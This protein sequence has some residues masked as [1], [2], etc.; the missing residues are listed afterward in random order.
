MVAR[1]VLDPQRPLRFN[2]ETQRVVIIIITSCH[3]CHPRPFT[4]RTRDKDDASSVVVY[5]LFPLLVGPS[6][7][8]S[9]ITRATTAAQPE[10]NYA[11]HIEI[12]EY[13]SKL[14]S[15]PSSSPLAVITR[16]CP[17]VLTSVS[18][19]LAVRSTTCIGADL[20]HCRHHHPLTD[21]CS[22][23]FLTDIISSRP[24][25]VVLQAQQTPAGA[26]FSFIFCFRLTAAISAI[27]E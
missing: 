15:S 27:L 14:S 4:T 22:P 17:A 12:A 10:N 9:L 11:L 8:D 18:V 1:P 20:R 2:T 26:E 25:S 3:Q 16:F 23:H 6:Q 13:I 21:N 19:S 24:Y 5:S 7:L